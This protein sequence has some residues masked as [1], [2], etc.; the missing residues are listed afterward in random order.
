MLVG[1]KQNIHEIK[2]FIDTASG[3]GFAGVH[4]MKGFYPNHDGLAKD[5]YL[6]SIYDDVD[7]PMLENYARQK[8]VLFT[9]NLGFRKVLEEGECYSPWNEFRLIITSNGWR[10]DVCCRGSCGIYMSDSALHDVHKFWHHERLDFIRRTVN[11]DEIIA[12]KMCL[13]CRLNIRDEKFFYDNE[14]MI[15]NKLKV[16]NK[17]REIYMD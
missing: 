15:D 14:D 12:N 6:D 16:N 8:K 10:C 3:L 9:T 7:I 17:F 5:S 2:K 11:T 1:L 4:L 13:R